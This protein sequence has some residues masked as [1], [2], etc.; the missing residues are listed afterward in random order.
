MNA[1]KDKAAVLI[2]EMGLT[3][4]SEFVP[5]SKS[6]NAGEKMPSLNWKVTVKYKGRPVLTTD[7]MAG[8]GHCPIDKKLGR[9]LYSGMGLSLWGYERILFECEKGIAIDAPR[10]EEG[11]IVP[12]KT[13]ITPDS[14]N[15]LYSL[16]IDSDAFEY[17]FE[18][19]CSN[20]GYDTD[21]RKAESMYNTCLE[22]SRQLIRAIGTDGLKKLQEAFQDY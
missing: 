11:L 4:E 7:Y 1:V 15:V 9:K 5:W 21:S 12:T 14:T 3:V 17:S 8:M 16:V 22:I 19:W 6:R 13:K 18:E 2:H 10:S 20:F